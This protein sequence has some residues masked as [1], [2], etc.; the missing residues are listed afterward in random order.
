MAECP[1]PSKTDYPTEVAARR[2]LAV[3]ARDPAR[4][5]APD[6][7]PYPCRCG[8][9]HLTSGTSLNARIRAALRS[10]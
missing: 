3:M 6:C 5:S 10:S 8:S 7:K 4:R 9:W 1:T 2:A